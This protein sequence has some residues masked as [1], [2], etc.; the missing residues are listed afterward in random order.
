MCSS[1]P[2]HEGV[3]TFQTFWGYV[4]SPTFVQLIS[5]NHLPIIENLANVLDSAIVVDD[6]LDT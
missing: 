2:L 6:E 5:V 1:E 3:V 4:N